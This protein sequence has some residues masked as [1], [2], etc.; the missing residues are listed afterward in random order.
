MMLPEAYQEL[1]NRIDVAMEVWTKLYDN[2]P[3]VAPLNERWPL[4][5][6]EELNRAGERV[7]SVK[8]E[9]FD[10]LKENDLL[11]VIEKELRITHDDQKIE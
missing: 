5:Y 3:P 8:A 2:P 1:L 6:R 4:W 10:F 7:H 11:T 9:M